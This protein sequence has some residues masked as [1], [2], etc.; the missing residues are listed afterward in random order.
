MA[1]YGAVVAWGIK[2]IADL[3][4]RKLYALIVGTAGAQQAL[5]F[6]YDENRL[7]EIAG[8]ITYAINN[9]GYSY[10]TAIR[11][12][13]RGAK[14]VQIGTGGTQNNAYGVPRGIG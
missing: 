11:I 6:S 12:D 2:L 5:L 10:Q 14:G 8:Q 3:S 1:G 7:R 9:P 4:K 13:L